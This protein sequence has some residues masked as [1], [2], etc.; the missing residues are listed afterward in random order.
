MRLLVVWI[1]SLFQR[2]INWYKNDFLQSSEGDLWKEANHILENWR[3]NLQNKGNEGIFFP[4]PEQG[5]FVMWVFETFFMFF[6][7]CSNVFNNYC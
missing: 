1:F 7:D 6:N 3:K 5:W 4:P 2:C